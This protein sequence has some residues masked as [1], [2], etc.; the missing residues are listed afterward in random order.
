MISFHKI[1]FQRNADKLASFD[2]INRNNNV[3]FS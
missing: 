2:T 1:Q 3:E